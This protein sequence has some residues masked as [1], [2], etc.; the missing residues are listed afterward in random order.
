MWR[1]DLSQRLYPLRRLL[2]CFCRVWV[3]ISI[4]KASVRPLPVLPRPF[5]KELE[6]PSPSVFF[7]FHLLLFLI[8][9]FTLCWKILGLGFSF[10]FSLMYW[11]GNCDLPH[12]IFIIYIYVCVWKFWVIGWFTMFETFSTSQ[13]MYCRKFC[14][15]LGFVLWFISWILRQPFCLYKS[16]DLSWAGWATSRGPW[17]DKICGPS[18]EIKWFPNLCSKSKGEL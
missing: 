17:Q 11:L 5:V 18:L 16:L 2:K 3:R 14:T 4:G 6:V 13:Y 8:S 12:F 9:S 15:H 7:P 10:I 1:W